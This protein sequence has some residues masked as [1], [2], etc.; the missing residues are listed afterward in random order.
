MPN[1]TANFCKGHYAWA[2]KIIEQGSPARF[3]CHE[4]WFGTCSA[5]GEHTQLCEKHFR[6]KRFKIPIRFHR[7]ALKA[8]MGQE[9]RANRQDEIHEY[10][11]HA[12]EVYRP[13]D[14]V[15]VV[16]AMPA[17]RACFADIMHEQQTLAQMPARTF[18]R[19]VNMGAMP[20]RLMPETPDAFLDGKIPSPELFAAATYIAWLTEGSKIHSGHVH[21]LTRAIRQALQDLPEEVQEIVRR[22]IFT[23]A[24]ALCARAV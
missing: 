8:F 19:C 1:I 13:E 15:D 4:A 23:D 20:R 21:D 3:L 9:Q 17:M 24:R 22:H 14:V 11:T 16:H 12:T 7:P 2:T 18:L 6:N 5:K 10:L